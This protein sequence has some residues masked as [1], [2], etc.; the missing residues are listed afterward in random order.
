MFVGVLLFLI[1]SYK[2]GLSGALRSMKI[3]NGEKTMEEELL[4]DIEEETVDKAKEF[5]LV[6]HN[7]PKYK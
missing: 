1:D 2:E 6:T 7:M 3:K 5:R 4:F